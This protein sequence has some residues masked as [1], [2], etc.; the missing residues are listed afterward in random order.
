MGLITWEFDGLGMDF[1][2]FLATGEFNCEDFLVSI[3]PSL[4]RSVYIRFVSSNEL[5]L[6]LNRFSRDVEIFW[7]SQRGSAVNEI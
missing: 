2:G 4:I 1:R 5:L 7:T 3:E 6:G